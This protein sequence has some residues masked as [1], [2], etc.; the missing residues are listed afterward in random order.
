MEHNENADL[1]FGIVAGIYY[2]LLGKKLPKQV[3]LLEEWFPGLIVRIRDTDGSFKEEPEYIDR[4]YVIEVSRYNG[5]LYTGGDR[6]ISYITGQLTG[7]SRSNSE[8]ERRTA[9]LVRRHV[10]RRLANETETFLQFYESAQARL[11]ELTEEQ[12]NDLH[13]RLWYFAFD[14]FDRYNG[15]EE[16]DRDNEPAAL[17]EDVSDRIIYNTLYQLNRYDAEGLIN[18]WLWLLTGSLLRNEAGRLTRN[19]DSSWVPLYRPPSETGT[20]E[21]Q[22]RFLLFPEEYESVYYGDTKEA[23]FPGIEWY[24]DNCGDHLNLQEGFD[25][26]L[27]VW[28]CRRCGVL[29]PLDDAHIFESEEDARIGRHIREPDPADESDE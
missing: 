21:D 4:E 6:R 14:L 3:D 18:A 28:Q 10:S 27:P 20:L 16:Y 29:N 2:D 12:I 24:C 13:K 22:L 7:T 25:D 15:M 5:Y 8:K 9:D 11:F 19:Y 26:R 1:R 17:D 23:R